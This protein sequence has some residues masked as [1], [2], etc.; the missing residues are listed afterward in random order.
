[1]PTLSSRP[2]TKVYTDAMI[3]EAAQPAVNIASW[4]HTQ[5]IFPDNRPETV[6]L[7]KGVLE[8]ALE[9]LMFPFISVFPTFG[10]TNELHF[11]INVQPFEDCK[12]GVSFLGK[13]RVKP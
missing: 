8:D 7:A 2:D 6:S 12:S 1:M 9:C 10:A 3:I 5:L 13:Y 4:L 11:I